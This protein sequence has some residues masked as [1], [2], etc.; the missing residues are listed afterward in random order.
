MATP[1]SGNSILGNNV[2][3]NSGNRLTTLV[4]LSSKAAS[5]MSWSFGTVEVTVVSVDVVEISE[6][7]S[8]ETL[9]KQKKS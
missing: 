9:Q 4:Y 5:G 7:S 1:P 3:I 2:R 8:A 6:G